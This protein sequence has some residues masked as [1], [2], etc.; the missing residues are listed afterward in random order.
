M[1]TPEKD[2]GVTF[3]ENLKFTEQI[4]N[5][6]CRSKCQNIHIHGQSCGSKHL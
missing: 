4:N 1:V 3:D 5:S 2:I 6:V